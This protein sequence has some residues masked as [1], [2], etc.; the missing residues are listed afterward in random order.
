MKKLLLLLILISL[1]YAC[2]TP[3][4]SRDCE[5]LINTGC[6]NGQ[7]CNEN[8]KCVHPCEMGICGN[9]TC[10]KEPEINGEA[11]YHCECADNMKKKVECCQ[12]EEYCSSLGVYYTEIDKT[13]DYYCYISKGCF[14]LPSPC[15]KSTDCA[16]YS[17]YVDNEIMGFGVC[18][19]NHE[20]QL[21][22]ENDNDCIGENEYC[23]K[24]E[25]TCYIAPFCIEYF[26]PVEQ[27]CVE[28]CQ[29][30]DDCPEPVSKCN[31]S[32]GHCVL[33][34]TA[35]EECTNFKFSGGS[36]CNAEK[37]FCD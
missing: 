12:E 4:L 18:N 22:C 35:D 26:S 2:G 13:S 8:Y 30:D 19:P 16:G 28:Y 31:K 15:N 5:Y 3:V 20:C 17:E 29:S 6:Q 25:K 9:E 37:G 21:R 7:I 36:N 27:S 11:Q 14:E 34:C 23:H 33:P 1:F 32:T 24:T 10:V